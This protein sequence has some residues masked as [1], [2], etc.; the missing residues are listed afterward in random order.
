MPIMASGRSQILVR[1]L[2]G[3]TRCLRFPERQVSVC[4]VLSTIEAADGV[5]FGVYRLVTGTKCVDVGDLLIADESGQLPSCAVLGRLLGGKGGFGSLLRGAGATGK[6]TTNFD[7]CRDLGGRRLRHVNAEKNLQKWKGDRKERDLE[8]VALKYCKKIAKETDE[9]LKK[10]D[11]EAEELRRAL[12]DTRGKVLSAVDEGI[13]TA[14]A[15]RKELAVEDAAAAKRVKDCS[16]LELGL[17]EDEYESDSE[18]G[19]DDD[20]DDATEV[21]AS[22]SASAGGSSRSGGAGPSGSDHSGDGGAVAGGLTVVSEVHETAGGQ[23]ETGRAHKDLRAHETVRATAA[24]AS[25]SAAASAGAALQSAAP[26]GAMSGGGER[27]PTADDA[28]VD[29][30][31]YETAVELEALG[32][33]CLKSALTSRGLKCG[34]TL[35][36]RASRLFLLKSTPLDKI[37]PKHKAPRRPPTGK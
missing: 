33:D 36:E 8:K 1:D 13:E 14:R 22:G 17:S 26:A 20:N 10:A 18:A 31:R 5:P 12:A 24:T 3:R 16:A 7:A 35:A 29:L 6:K 32:L 25:T 11:L 27:N 28:D 21:R 30:S 37:D 23:E 15:K 34:G 4:D 19:S 2:E 9:G